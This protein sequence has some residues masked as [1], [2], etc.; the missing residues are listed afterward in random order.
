MIKLPAGQMNGKLTSRHQVSGPVAS[1]SRDD[2]E[3][4]RRPLGSSDFSVTECWTHLGCESS[5]RRQAWHVF[6]SASATCPTP[7]VSDHI[8]WA[9]QKPSARYSNWL[10]E[11]FLHGSLRSR[12]VGCF[13]SHY[14]RRSGCCVGFLGGLFD[15]SGWVLGIFN[16][17]ISSGIM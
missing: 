13:R 1:A 9:G 11:G 17:I 6:L 16:Y 7:S 12:I 4:L 5:E 3:E 2:L 8:S 10:T 14:C 15:T